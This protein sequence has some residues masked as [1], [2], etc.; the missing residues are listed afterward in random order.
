MFYGLTLLN[1][2]SWTG[3]NCLMEPM[4]C[5]AD[6]VKQIEEGAVLLRVRYSWANGRYAVWQR[7]TE[8]SKNGVV[9]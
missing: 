1:Q 2:P 7:R 5:L 9:E 8:N 4:S 3:R 6:Q